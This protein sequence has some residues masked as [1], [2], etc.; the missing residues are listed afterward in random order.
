MW[1]AYGSTL[2]PLQVFLC[3]HSRLQRKEML[4][5]SSI[6]R[7]KQLERLQSAGPPVDRRPDDAAHPTSPA[8]V[9]ELRLRL[10]GLRDG[11]VSHTEHRRH[12]GHVSG[13]QHAA[14]PAHGAAH[15]PDQDLRIVLPHWWGSADPGRLRP[16]PAPAQRGGPATATR[17]R[18][19]P[20]PWQPRPQLGESG[21]CEAHQ[22]P[23]MVHSTP[24]GCPHASAGLSGVHIAGPARRGVQLGQRGHR[25]QRHHRHLP[26]ES[27]GAEVQ[28]AVCSVGRRAAVP[29]QRGAPDGGPAGPPARAGV[30]PGD[31]RGLRGRGVPACQLCRGHRGQALRQQGVSVGGGGHGAGGQLHE[32]LRRDLRPGRAQTRSGPVGLRLQGTQLRPS[33][34]QQ[35]GGSAGRQQQQQQWQREGQEGQGQA[36]SPGRIAPHQHA[37][38]QRRQ[39]GGAL[40]GR[41]AGRPAAAGPASPG[42]GPGGRGAA[43]SVLGAVLAAG[44]RPSPGPAAAGR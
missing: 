16:V 5:P 7:R 15:H 10:P 44:G 25:G 42:P 38:A 34:W 4:L 13:R 20:Q 33:H 1:E 31:G 24:T 6:Q 28:D 11:S 8:M 26:A 12:H 19:R 3:L 14:L 18:T 37:P 40:P 36:V 43:R 35:Q 9:C 39:R 17:R 27:R 29:Q 30:P 22:V 23:W 21:L 2:R 41:P 32:R